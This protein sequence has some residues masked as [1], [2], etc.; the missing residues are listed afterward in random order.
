MFGVAVDCEQESGAPVSPAN[1]LVPNMY[2]LSVGSVSVHARQAPLMQYCPVGQGL[3][4]SIWLLQLS[5]I[6]LQ[7]SVCGVFPVH[8]PYAPLVHVCVPVHVP[9]AFVIWH[10]FVM[11]VVQFAKY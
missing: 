2:M 1:V 11:P 7:V 6:P 9:Y 3:F 5:S 10:G 8:V 4:S